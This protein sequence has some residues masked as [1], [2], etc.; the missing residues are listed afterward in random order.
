MAALY[1]K[2]NSAIQD[3][4]EKDVKLLEIDSELFLQGPLCV[5]LELEQYDTVR[6][7]LGAGVDVNDCTRAG[8]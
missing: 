3:I 4:P 2:Q 5:A 7:L 1:L 8:G 6:E